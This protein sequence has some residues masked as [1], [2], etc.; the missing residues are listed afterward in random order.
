MS[1]KSKPPTTEKD[2]GQGLV[3]F[4]RLPEKTKELLKLMD[5]A[6]K[7]IGPEQVVITKEIHDKARKSQP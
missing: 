1:K 6:E 4:E 7:T 2:P 3:T 5:Q